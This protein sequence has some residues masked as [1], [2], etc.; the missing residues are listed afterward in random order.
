MLDRLLR[1]SEQRLDCRQAVAEEALEG[2]RASAGSLRQVVKTKSTQPEML[3][4]VAALGFLAAHPGRPLVKV[5][6]SMR[7][8]ERAIAQAESLVKTTQEA[9]AQAASAAEAAAT[10]EAD[11]P[12]HETA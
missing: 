12:D 11:G 7:D 6:L 2:F 9:M 1:G 5:T 10:G 4:G 3:A 8:I